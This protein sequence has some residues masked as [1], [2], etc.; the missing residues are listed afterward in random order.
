MG[1][2]TAEVGVAHARSRDAARRNDA[3]AQ[4]E[5]AAQLVIDECRTVL[6]GIQALFGFQLIAVFNTGFASKLSAAEQRT[7][8]HL[9]QPGRR[10]QIRP[11]RATRT[12]RR[13]A[14]DRRGRAI[15]RQAKIALAA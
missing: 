13:F 15:P 7:L 4:L 3:T 8:L 11:A 2:A 14:A 1:R 6:P 5:D 12:R 9:V 10:P